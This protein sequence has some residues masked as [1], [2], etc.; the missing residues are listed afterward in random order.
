MSVRERGISEPGAGWKLAVAG[1]VGLACATAAWVGV[2]TATMKPQPGAGWVA[3]WVVCAVAT[4]AGPWRPTLALM[5]YIVAAYATPRYGH[6]YAT[7]MHA[8]ALNG[9]ALCVLTGCGLFVLRRGGDAAWG[10]WHLAVMLAFTLWLAVCAA[11]AAVRG[12]AWA[13]HP[14]HHPL[15]FFQ[16]LAVYLAAAWGMRGREQFAA[17]AA[18]LCAALLARGF[19][20][21][22]EGLALEGDASF[23]SVMALPLALLGFQAARGWGAK[24][25]F[26]L[27]AVGLVALLALTRNRGAAVAFVVLL[28]VLGW[29]CLRGPFRG[30]GRV[31]AIAAPA[32]LIAGVVFAQSDYWERFTGIWRGT[33]HANSVRERVMI[34][35]ASR[36]VIAEHPVFGVGTGNFHNVLREYEPAMAMD[37]AAHNNYIHVLAETG[38]IGLALYVGVFGGALWLCRRTW[39]AAGHDWPAPA[40]RM[41]F[42]SL[43]AYLAA[44][45]FMS[46]HDLPL[47]Y[48]LCGAAVG[49]W[50]GLKIA[51]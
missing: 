43:I 2:A 46:R 25:G 31:L 28:P 7:L 39:R 44:G 8:G 40:A 27:G 13:P 14:N 35:Q 38:F 3:F 11:V 47:A 6:A 45:F 9:M 18:A 30:R 19:V 1:H 42:A 16:G 24:G 20:S 33:D 50:R 36:R 48:L 41:V 22:R 29:H 23:L 49:G 17:L 37:F 26:A 4:A 51:D 15:L 12:S 21:G 5:G 10:R 34:W 32:L